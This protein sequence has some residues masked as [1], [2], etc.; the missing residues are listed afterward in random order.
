MIIYHAEHGAQA[1]KSQLWV[2]SSGRIEM[3]CPSDIGCPTMTSIDVE[4]HED[5]IQGISDRTISV[6]LKS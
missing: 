5:V 2:T 6:Q 3:L 1:D 4:E